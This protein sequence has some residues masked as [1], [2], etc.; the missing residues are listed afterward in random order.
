MVRMKTVRGA[1]RRACILR[2]K[3]TIFI[4]FLPLA[5]RM[6]PRRFVLFY[7][8]LLFFLRHLRHN[9]YAL[10]GRK[11]RLDLYVPFF[12]SRAFDTACEKFL[13]FDEKM[14]C[15]TVLLSV[16]SACRFA[17]DHCYQ[18]HDRG[19][20]VALEVLV[21]SA[22][23]LQDKGVAFFNIEGGEPFLAY[24]RLKAVCE[25]LDERSEIWVNSTGDGMSDQRIAEL[26][27]RNLT[28]VMF[29]LHAPEPDT[30]NRFMGRERAWDC[31]RRGIA[32][33]HAHDVMVAFNMCLPASAFYDGT[34]ERCMVR[35]AEFGG[36]IVQLIKPKPAGAWLHEGAARFSEAD[37]D[38]V[39]LL[40]NRYN[41]QPS[42]REYPPVC[43]QI[44][45]EAPDAFGCTAGGTD[46]FYINAKGDLQPCEFLNISFGNIGRRNFD[47]IFSD[48][49]CH[50]ERPGTTWL[51]ESC[52]TDIARIMKNNGTKTLPL[53]P[54]L[55][56]S[57][58]EHWDRGEKTRLYEV[59]EREMR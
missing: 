26:K 48:M 19:S 46:R 20:D 16:T 2:M 10:W 24:P 14:P 31:M 23:G 54:E 29:S 22:R 30:F 55:S 8:R 41:H 36:A 32:C 4:H 1:R 34:F 45:E 33:C 58:Y 51:C 27:E 42:L 44:L 21:D 5:L 49:R 15:S 59:I 25:V 47:Q 6:P 52:S 57:I 3:L 7:T 12:P 11:A 43:A 50:F 37:M 53:S 56:A 18:R 13:T 40:V 9:K 28:A 35:A 38:R 39:R 17:C